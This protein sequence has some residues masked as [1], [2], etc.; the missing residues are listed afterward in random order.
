M[1]SKVLTIPASNLL[2]HGMGWADLRHSHTMHF[3]LD[4]RKW[5]R[6]VIVECTTHET[7]CEFA[8]IHVHLCCDDLNT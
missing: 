4:I 2:P 8:R 7:L 3:K 1:T 5:G 6:E